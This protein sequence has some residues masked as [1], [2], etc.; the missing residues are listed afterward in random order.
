MSNLPA[1][2]AQNQGLIIRLMETQVELSDAVRTA[3]E[4]TTTAI[5]AIGEKTADAIEEQGRRIGRIEAGLEEFAEEQRQFN[6][7]SE[8]RMGRVESDIGATKGGHVRTKLAGLI[9]DLAEEIGIEEPDV[10]PT[11]ELVA[12]ARRITG[13]IRDEL[14]SFRQADL[15]VRGTREGETVYLAVE[16]SWT[17]DGT[18][19]N[20]ASRNAGFITRATGTAAIPVIASVRNTNEAT[21]TIDAGQVRWYRIEERDMQAE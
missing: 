6:E 15:V 9:P 4:A 8:A 18:D 3:L 21:E 11:E 12:M 5:G 19:T 1:A 7:R 14:R 20:R 2:V 10:V 13:A 16:A 17:A